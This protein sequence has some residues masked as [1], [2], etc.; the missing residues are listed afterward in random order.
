MS[1]GLSIIYYSNINSKEWSI[2]E[3]LS[4]DKSMSQDDLTLL[5]VYLLLL[6]TKPKSSNA[7]LS[8]QLYRMIADH[9]NRLN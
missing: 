5:R 3:E 7:E 9:R 6:G 8:D 4:K 1:K 2:L